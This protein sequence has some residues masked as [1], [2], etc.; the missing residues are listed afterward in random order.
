M[1]FS[2]VLFALERV[3]ECVSV[4]CCD[5]FYFFK[6][7]L[8]LLYICIIEQL[9]CSKE[10]KWVCSSHKNIELG[11]L[12]SFWCTTSKN[13]ARIFQPRRG[14]LSL[15]LHAKH[16]FSFISFVL[17]TCTSSFCF[18]LNELTSLRWYANNKITLYKIP[19]RSSKSDEFSFRN[20]VWHVI[21]CRRLNVWVI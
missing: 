12:I 17:S 4:Y 18:V 20:Q 11:Q 8:F 3:F 14:G 6:L 13:Y 2:Q 16:I 19:C 15:G 7:F 10:S 21:L 1:W 5:I 9:V